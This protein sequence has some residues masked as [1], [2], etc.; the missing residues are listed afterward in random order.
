MTSAPARIDLVTIFPDYLAPLGLSLVGRARRAGLLDVHVHDLRDWADDRHR[1]VDDTPAGGGAGMVMRP[2]V[3]GRAL[4]D[5]LDPRAG[6]VL[7][8]PTPAGARFTQSRAEV[9][10]DDLAAGRRLVVACGRYEGIDGRVA[11]HYSHAPGVRVEEISIGDY[12]L[13][14]GEAAALVLVEAV[15]RLLPGVLGNPESLAEESHGQGGL[16]EAP[17]YTRPL[18]WRGLAVPG[19]LRSGHHGRIAA[20]RRDLALARTAERR[21]DMLADLDVGS[22]GARDRRTLARLGWAVVGPRVQRFRVRPARPADVEAVADLA[23]ATFP[24]ACPPGS[25]PDDVAAFVAEHLGRAVFARYLAAPERWSL[26]VAEVVPERGAE[27]VLETGTEEVSG[28]PVPTTH[29]LLGYTLAVLPRDPDEGPTDPSVAAAVAMRPVA[30]LSKCYVRP[31]L[32]GSGVADALLDATHADLG[33]RRICS[34][35]LSAVW[36]GTNRRNRRARRFYAR[37]GYRQVGERVFEVGRDRQA[38][39]VLV[40]RLGGE[41]GAGTEDLADESGS[42]DLHAAEGPDDGVGAGT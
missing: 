14:G 18:D 23:A 30:E 10:A 16:L 32:H 17:V 38:D 15:T 19:V 11:E 2:D 37:A 7:V 9:L 42:S 27:E 35:P 20:W 41:R 36:L 6:T 1:T 31:A 12:V 39:V 13:A 3:W 28:S 8:V 25:H 4:D 29:G 22:L 26:L 34:E 33:A 24:L 40:R 5:V 21:P